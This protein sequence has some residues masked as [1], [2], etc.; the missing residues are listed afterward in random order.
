M[1]S[2]IQISSITKISIKF[3]IVGNKL[4]NK[5]NILQLKVEILIL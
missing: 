2:N 1:F 5:I 4:K 3:K